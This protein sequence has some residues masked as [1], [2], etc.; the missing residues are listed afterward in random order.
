[1]I[2]FTVNN[3]L[4]TIDSVFQGDVFARSAG[5]NFRHGEGL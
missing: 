4:E 1:M 5:K 3:S 2:V